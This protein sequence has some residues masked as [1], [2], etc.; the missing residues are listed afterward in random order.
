MCP[1]A[2]E[3]VVATLGNNIVL[4]SSP[5]GACA[6]ENAIQNLVTK[7]TKFNRI[8]TFVINVTKTLVINITTFYRIQNFV[9]NVTDFTTA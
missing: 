1:L 8:Q 7:V 3:D 2:W 5:A 9:T 4:I 6:S